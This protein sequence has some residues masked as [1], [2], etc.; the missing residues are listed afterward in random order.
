M[1][2]PSFSL[3]VASLASRAALSSSLCTSLTRLRSLSLQQGAVGVHLLRGHLV[4]GQGARLVRADDGDGAQALHRLEILHNSVLAGHLL[5][6]HG[7]HDGDNGGQ[8]LGD[9][10]HGQGHGKHEGVQN[11]HAGAED[12]QGKHHRA[13]GHD[14]HGQLG[15]EA[16]QALLQGVLR[17]WVWF[18]RAAILP[19]SVSMP[20]PVTS[21]VARP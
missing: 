7:Q 5:G 1:A 6:A 9:S 15:G 10:G 14:D 20:V 2:V 4:L 8:G 17:C 12:G 16:V 19:S 18:M 3:L 13:D 11:A 21:T